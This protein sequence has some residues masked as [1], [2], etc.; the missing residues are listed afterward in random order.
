MMTMYA[1]FLRVLLGV[2]CTASMMVQS[3]H[4]QMEIRRKKKP[5]AVLFDH[6]ESRTNLFALVNETIGIPLLF[7]EV[8]VI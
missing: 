3:A 4:R 1:V 5:A 6:T 7:H 2:F 8:K